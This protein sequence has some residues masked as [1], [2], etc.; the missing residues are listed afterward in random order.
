MNQFGAHLN[1]DLGPVYHVSRCPL[2]GREVVHLVLGGRRGPVTV[3]LLPGVG[4]SEPHAVTSDR[5]T[6]VLL[7][8]A[9][10]VLRPE[11]DAV[12]SDGKH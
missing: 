4:M 5:Y 8:A 9:F 1:G 2:D 12:N 3:L 10:F 11:I 7:P 6:G